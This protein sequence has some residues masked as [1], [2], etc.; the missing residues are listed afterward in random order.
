MLSNH[1]VKDV[2]NTSGL[3]QNT[4][5]NNIPVN[6]YF[7]FSANYHGNTLYHKTISMLA[8]SFMP[9][10]NILMYACSSNMLAWLMTLISSI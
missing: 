1:Q 6:L 2:P 10:V 3:G 7:V 8:F 5:T 4:S 9:C